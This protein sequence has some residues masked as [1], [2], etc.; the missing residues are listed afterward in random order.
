MG[1]SPIWHQT[2]AAMPLGLGIAPLEPGGLGIA[3]LAPVLPL[4]PL[5]EGGDEG[6]QRRQLPLPPFPKNCLAC[7]TR[8]AQQSAKLCKTNS[9]FVTIRYEQNCHSQTISVMT[10]RFAPPTLSFFRLAAL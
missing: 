6:Q 4:L 10:C 7:L 5:G 8:K 1:W 9:H 2:T 3:L